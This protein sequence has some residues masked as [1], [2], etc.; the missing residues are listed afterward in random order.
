VSLDGREVLPPVMAGAAGSQAERCLAPAAGTAA[1]HDRLSAG[2]HT[3]TL[4]GLGPAWVQL[5]RL[6]VPDIGRDV[7]AH[8]IADRDFALVRVQAD[9]GAVPATVGLHV[10]ELRDG[11]CTLDLIDLATGAE[12]QA[13]AVINGAWPRELSSPPVTPRW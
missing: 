12:R 5:D 10:D 7:R 3:I 6:I 11:P 4:E 2:T 1:D 8:A 13:A 9:D